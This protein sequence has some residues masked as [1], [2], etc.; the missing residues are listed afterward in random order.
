MGFAFLPIGI[1]SLIGGRFGGALIHRYGEIAH[2]PAKI[3][4]AVTGVG[5]LTT[6]LMV[7]YDL[8]LKPSAKVPE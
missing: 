1:G 8:M 5:V 7:L 4:W 3:W 2:Q 6:V